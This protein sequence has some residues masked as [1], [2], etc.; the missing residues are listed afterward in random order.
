MKPC[1]RID[2]QGEGKVTFQE[3]IEELP[4]GSIIALDSSLI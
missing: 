2:H 3:Q 4:D 1:I